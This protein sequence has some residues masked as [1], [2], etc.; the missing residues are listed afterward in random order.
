MAHN[1]RNEVAGPWWSRSRLARLGVLRLLT[2]RTFSPTTPSRPGL[3]KTDFQRTGSTRSRRMPTATCGRHGQRPRA[4]DGIRSSAR[5]PFIR[6]VE[7]SIDSSASL[8][9]RRLDV[10]RPGERGGVGHIEQTGCV[11]SARQTVSRPGVPIAE[12]QS[13]T[14]WIAS[15]DGLFFKAA[16]ATKWSARAVWLGLSTASSATAWRRAGGRRRG[17]SVWMSPRGRSR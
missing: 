14:L 5:R 7:S 6:R 16:T 4:I 17:C 9:A 2:S 12:D 11:C 15:G 3:R 8:R 10:V 1:E 13:D